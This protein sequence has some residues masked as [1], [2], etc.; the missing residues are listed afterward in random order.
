MK[1]VLTFQFF[2]NPVAY[3]TNGT[4]RFSLGGRILISKAIE[5]LMQRANSKMHI[6]II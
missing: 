3:V 2:F 1:Y 4:G 5:C 6:S